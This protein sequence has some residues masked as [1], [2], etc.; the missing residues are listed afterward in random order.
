MRHL[1]NIKMNVERPTEVADDYGTVTTTWAML[2]YQQPCRVNWLKGDEKVFTDRKSHFRDAKVYC[3]VIDIVVKDRITIGGNVFEVIEVANID[4]V[5]K[6]LT[7]FLEK[8]S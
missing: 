3:D 4:N 7:I 5:G 2:H 8:I 6:F 1:F